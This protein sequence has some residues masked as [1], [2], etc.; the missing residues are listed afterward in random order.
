[1][2]IALPPSSD[3]PV[4]PRPGPVFVATSFACAAGTMLLGAMVAVYYHFR[5][6]AG[7]KTASWL[8]ENAHL[9]GIP[10]NTML[11]T[12][13]VASVMAQW[14]VY[15]AARDD[16]RNGAVALLLTT[17]FGVLVINAQ[18]AL[19]QQFGQPLVPKQ[20]SAYNT[21][22]YT[23]TGTFVAALL[24]G[25]VYA[26]VTA[27]RFVAGR[28]TASDHEGV[29]ALALYW[30]FLTAAFAVVWFVVYVTK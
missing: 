3:V 30:H 21:I 5:D 6:L 27:F 16:R 15:A 14:S 29:S 26:A 10:A 25:V 23:I 22:F 9:P 2:S 11:V 24:T 20:A 28:Y 18:L 17:V 19:Y 8:P 4:R 12:M 1:M 13:L 7:G